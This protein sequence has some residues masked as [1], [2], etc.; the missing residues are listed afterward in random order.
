M[1]YLLVPDRFAEQ[2]L[3]RSE[4]GAEVGS[5]ANLQE[6]GPLPL[7]SSAGASNV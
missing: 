4:E 3:G 5:G 1:C 6:L 2:V 7:T